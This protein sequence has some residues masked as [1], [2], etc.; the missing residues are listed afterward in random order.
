MLT[1][2]CNTFI[3]FFYA[4]QEPRNITSPAL[5][6]LEKIKAARVAAGVAKKIAKKARYEA[7]KQVQEAYDGLQAEW[8]NT[9]ESWRIAARSTGR[10]LRRS[11]GCPVRAHRPTEAEQT[12]FH[13]ARYAEKCSEVG[14]LIAKIIKWEKLGHD[15][16]YIKILTELDWKATSIRQE[17]SDRPFDTITRREHLNLEGIPDPKIINKAYV[18]ARRICT[19]TKQPIADVLVDMHIR[20]APAYWNFNNTCTLH[21]DIIDAITGSGILLELILNGCL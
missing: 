11:I 15:P 4:H 6:E 13:E 17:I 1:W 16:L 20:S 2:I 3:N 18:S 9:S 21:F 7:K 19:S 12:P 8:A 5:A 14:T 10:A